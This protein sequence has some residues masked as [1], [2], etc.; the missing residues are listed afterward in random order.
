MFHLLK[1]T[2]ITICDSIMFLGKTLASTG[3]YS[4]PLTNAAGCDS[5]VNLNLKINSNYYK[6]NVTR[7]DGYVW[8]L[9]GKSLTLPNVFRKIYKQLR[10]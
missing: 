6:Q 9:N 10:L 3:N 2:S 1:D 5:V 7:C 8:D 4:F